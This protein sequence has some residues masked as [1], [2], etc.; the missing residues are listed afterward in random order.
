ML[1]VRSFLDHDR[2][3]IPPSRSAEPRLATAINAVSDAAYVDNKQGALLSPSLAF[4]SLVEHWE[5]WAACLGTH[6]LLV[7]EVSN[8]DVVSSVKYMAEATS[9]HFDSVQAHSGQMLMPA[10]HFS[11]GAASAGLLP[12]PGT[13]TYPKDSAYTCIVLQHLLPAGVKVSVPPTRALALRPRP[14]PRPRPAANSRP[15]GLARRA[16]APHLPPALVKAFSGTWSVQS[17]LLLLRAWCV[18][19][20]VQL[21]ALQ[22]GCVAVDYW[23]APM[24]A[25]KLR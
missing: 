3:F 5:R 25:Q 2:P 18:C 10:T 6:G 1:H 21:F 23:L 24:T 8:L 9:L 16:P 14:R 7:L 15:L 19:I 22:R 4:H 17:T 20:P 13:L 12:S 11:L